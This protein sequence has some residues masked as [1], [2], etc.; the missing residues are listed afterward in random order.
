MLDERKAAVLR[1]V[2]EHYIESA[3]P[4]GSAHVAR[5]PA[6]AVSSATVRNDMHVLEREGYL[7][8]PHTSAGRIPTDRGYRYFVDHLA[9]QD[10]LDPSQMRTVSAFFD[11]A[12]GRLD[13][14]MTQT[15]AL[16]A[17]LTDCA[18]V[19]VPPGQRSAVVR[20]I[21]I[22][23]LT[24]SHALVVLVMSDGRVERYGL[25]LGPGELALIDDANQA[26]A[27]LCVDHAP[28]TLGAFPGTD[29]SSILVQRVLALVA[30][31][32]DSEPV[33]Q[34]AHIGG[35]SRMASAFDAV[36]TVR[37]VLGALEEQFLVVTLLRDLV[38]QGLS[39][40]IG[41]EHGVTPLAQCSVVVAPV[42][43]G[44]GGTI[45]VVGPT[46]MHYSQ[47]LATLAVVGDRMSEHVQASS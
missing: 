4:V 24:D 17:S 22:V 29:G 6:L 16:L 34:V 9:S 12:H 38:D 21:Q 23:S 32:R 42:D 10:P 2:V 26:L 36:D 37:R 33:E 31:E 40:S 46:R 28:S 41:A 7:T 1:A 14:L 27:K 43:G 45:A 35:A 25:D 11:R 3:Q 15:A 13:E 19:V 20:S 47:A 8:Q 5:E 18:A 30:D 39:V 44:R